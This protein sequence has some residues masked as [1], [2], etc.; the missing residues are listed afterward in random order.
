MVVLLQ[1]TTTS[2]RTLKDLLDSGI[3]LGALDIVYNHQY[4]KVYTHSSVCSTGVQNLLESGIA[5]GALDIVYNHQ[6]IKV[7]KNSSA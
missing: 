2:I 4:I 7:S 5:L 3:T 6:Y 1:S